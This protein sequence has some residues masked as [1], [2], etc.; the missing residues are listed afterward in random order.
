MARLAGHDLDRDDAFVLGLVGQHGA[1][2]DVAD[3]MDALH[4]GLEVLVHRD[5]AVAVHLD[6]ELFEAEI[7]RVG[8]PPDG[9]QHHVGLEGFLLGLGL[10]RVD[11]L[12][13]QRDAAPGF[14]SRLGPGDLGRQLEIDPLFGEDTL[15]LLGHF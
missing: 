14:G 6:P 13:G 9:D 5:E 2:D 12:H 8:T 7:F 11:G 4:I 1:A 10:F 15:H 3:G